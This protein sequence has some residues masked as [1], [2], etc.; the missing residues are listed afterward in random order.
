MEIFKDVVI[1]E[2]C[3]RC[4]NLSTAGGLLGAGS[5]SH[6]DLPQLATFVTT[7]SCFCLGC[8]N[9]QIPSGNIRFHII[10]Q[11][12]SVQRGHTR[13]SHYGACLRRKQNI[14]NFLPF[15]TVLWSSVGHP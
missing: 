3:V 9:V 12:P 8:T 13:C 4:R 7:G 11:L 15:F 10:R 1:R 6:L 14:A 5:D 2:G